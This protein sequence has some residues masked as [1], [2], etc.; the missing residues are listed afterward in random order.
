MSFGFTNVPTTFIDLMNRVFKPYLDMFVI[1]FIGD[2]LIYSRNEEDHDNRLRIVLQ[3][4]KNKDLYV[5]FSKCEFWFKLMTF[6]GHI[7]SSDGIR[8]NTQKIEELQSWPRP[9][10]L[11][12]IRSFLGLDDYYRRFV[13]RFSSISST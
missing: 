11:T 1:I 12:D 6:L 4:L 13:K 2:I 3:T 10:S 5:K 8:V 7:V 9:T